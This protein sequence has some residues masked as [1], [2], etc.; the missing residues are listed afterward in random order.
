MNIRNT[1][2][3]LASFSDL[4]LSFPPLTKL[5]NGI[6]CWV[7]DGGEDDMNRVSVFINAG[8]M[9]ENKTAVATLTAIMLTEGTHK[10][11][12]Q[13]VAEQFDYYA[14]RKI[15]DSY[16]YWTEVTMTSLNDNFEH[17]MS[18][19][20][21]CITNPSFP[22]QELDYYKRCIAGNLASM[23][24]N[25]KYQATTRLKELYYG[26]VN[27]MGVE[28]SLDDIDAITRDDLVEFHRRFFMPA[29]CKV[30]ISGK[31]TQNILDTLNATL[32][33]WSDNREAISEPVWQ[34]SPS[35]TMFDIV[36]RPGALQSAL[37]IRIQAVKRDHPDYLPLRVLVT[38]LGGYFG[39][40]LMMN[41]REDKG[42]T[43]GIH[44][45]LLGI[46][47]DGC[48]DIQCECATEH[49]WNVIDEVKNEMKLL[50]EELVPE[51]ELDAVRQHMLS[52]MAKTHDTPYNIASYVTTTLLFG[53]YPEYHNN[54]L[55][56]V[57][58][59]TPQHIQQLAQKYL[60]DDLMRIV[61]AGDEI[62]L[63]KLNKSGIDK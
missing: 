39:S 55:H 41:I 27:P 37:H 50:R 44:A 61:I 3:P 59:I 17:T 23:Q 14:A 24:Q 26:N 56:C 53:V 22:Q 30:V 45:S 12:A 34:T 11:S 58:S 21:D 46:Q 33:K 57:S 47:H 62:E 20:Y 51:S 8:T 5:E 16:D 32:G 9:M 38:I 18:L 42:Y 25:V 63:G 10:L 15:A 52:A 35:S 48:I 4:T 43:Y 54:Q 2:P 60:R 29:A 1:P 6:P 49:T 28:I 13:Q 36:N 40:R 31:I 7:I 19:L